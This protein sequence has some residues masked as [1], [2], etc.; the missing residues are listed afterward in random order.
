[1]ISSFGFP[2]FLQEKDEIMHKK[3]GS[4]ASFHILCISSFNILSLDAVSYEVDKLSLNNSESVIIH[5]GFEVLTAV[6]TKMAV[7]WVVAPC[8][9]V[10]V[11]QR[12]IAL[13]M[14]AARISETSVNFY[15]TTRRYN[16][17]DSHLCNYSCL[18]PAISLY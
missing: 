11:N 4:S 15:Q 13:M 18:F 3:I 8:S 6:S 14:E 17:E 12:F 7:F 10:E 9:V 5:V 1:M 2:Q 16:P